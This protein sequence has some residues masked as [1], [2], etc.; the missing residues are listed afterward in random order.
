MLNLTGEVLGL[1][2][3]MFPFQL[4]FLALVGGALVV[5]WQRDTDTLP[6]DVAGAR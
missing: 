5:S 1:A 4:L 6:T 2:P 3:E